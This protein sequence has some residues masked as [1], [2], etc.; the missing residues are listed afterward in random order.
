MASA[1]FAH[2]DPSVR[3]AALLLGGGI[4]SSSHG[5]KAAT[6]IGANLSPEPFSNFGLSVFEDLIVIGSSFVIALP[7]D[8]DD[9]DRFSLL[10]CRL[11]DASKNLFHTVAFCEERLREML[12]LTELHSLLRYPL[13]RAKHADLYSVAAEAL[14]LARF[15]R[16]SC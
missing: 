9:R 13:L 10:V 3:V 8:R 1:A 6:R 12:F 4:A 14:A 16:R 2:Y 7:S 11:V 5:T 15:L